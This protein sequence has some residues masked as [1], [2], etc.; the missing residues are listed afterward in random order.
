MDRKFYFPILAGIAGLTLIMIAIGMAFQEEEPVR[1]MS[2]V[3]PGVW[4]TPTSRQKPVSGST[5][6]P[7][8][9]S[10]HAKA[11]KLWEGT[12]LPAIKDVESEVGLKFDCAFK[13]DGRVIDLMAYCKAN[14]E[15]MILAMATTFMHDG[16]WTHIAQGLVDLG[17]IFVLDECVGENDKEDFCDKRVVDEQ[18][19]VL[20]LLELATLFSRYDG[21]RIQR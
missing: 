14:D 16:T 1:T 3:T 6:I 4:D 12:V 2:T 13:S 5:P 7:T 15:D 9:I 20:A 21:K 18:E 19:G 17:D 10:G 11:M 8:P